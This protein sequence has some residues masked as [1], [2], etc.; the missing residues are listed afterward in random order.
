MNI[1][2]QGSTSVAQSMKEQYMKSLNSI[3]GLKGGPP[4]PNAG[5][6]GQTEENKEKTKKIKIPFYALNQEERQIVFRVKSAKQ[7]KKQAE[8]AKNKK[9]ML[10]WKAQ[11]RREKLDAAMRRKKI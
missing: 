8:E 3:F 6:D 5:T 2:L 1:D 7:D 10:E 11:Q 4:D 9:E